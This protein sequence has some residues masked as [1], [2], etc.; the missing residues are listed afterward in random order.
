MNRI[1]KVIREWEAD[2]T[3]LSDKE[4]ADLLGRLD[5]LV[6]K[7]IAEAIKWIREKVKKAEERRE[8]KVGESQKKRDR[9][10]EQDASRSK[11]LTPRQKIAIAE[12]ALKIRWTRR[13][14]GAYI[15]PPTACAPFPE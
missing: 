11:C 7:I 12:A 4:R 8:L 13:K 10:K 2:W 14:E 9:R 6:E 15:P 5:P 1:E 3:P